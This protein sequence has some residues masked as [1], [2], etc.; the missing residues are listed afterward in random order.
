MVY[1][2]GLVRSANNQIIQYFYGGS[3]LDQVKQ[4]N[5]KLNLVNMSNQKIRDT[6]VFTK[7]ELKDMYKKNELTKAEVLNEEFYKKL[8]EF[9][10]ELRTIVTKATLSYVT[11][12]DKFMLP[13]NLPRVI[14]SNISSNTKSDLTYQDVIDTIEDIGY[15]FILI[16]K[17]KKYLIKPS[18]IIDY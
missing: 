13:V 12:K 3:N 17:G 9:R 14:N 11:M 18:S 16:I 8:V 2:D 7:A 1:Y 10:N 15:D 4:S 6:L 5:I